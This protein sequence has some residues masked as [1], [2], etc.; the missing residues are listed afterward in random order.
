M[1]DCRLLCEVPS[2]YSPRHG[3]VL[4]GDDELGYPEEAEDVDEERCD[5]HPV[6]EE[7]VRNEASLTVLVRV[8]DG[9][10]HQE[11]HRPAQGRDDQRG[12]G[13]NM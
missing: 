13:L 11:R 2:G 7:T 6:G 1:I 3:H 8:T 10:Q 9:E 12:K 5:G 4:A